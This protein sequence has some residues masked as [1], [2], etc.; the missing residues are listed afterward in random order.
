MLNPF[1][2]VANPDGT[3][4]L[5][6]KKCSTCLFTGGRMTE[7]MRAVVDDA[8]TRESYVMCHET[9]EHSDFEPAEGVQPAMCRGYFDAYSPTQY[10]LQIVRRYKFY[11]EVPAPP[12]DPDQRGYRMIAEESGQ[13]IVGRREE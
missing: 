12:E 2:R 1:E 4:R 9:Y 13:F 6:A 8:R 5:C 7:G 11:E 3:P 10:G